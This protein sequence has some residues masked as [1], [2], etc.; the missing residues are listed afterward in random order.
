MRQEASIA[1]AVA[2]QVPIAEGLTEA[3]DAHAH[4]PDYKSIREQ[5]TGQDDEKYQ[6]AKAIRE[7][8]L[9][10]FVPQELQP[11]FQAAIEA[12]DGETIDEIL[13]IAD[14]EQSRAAAQLYKGD[15]PI[16]SNPILV[17]GAIAATGLG[18]FGIVSTLR[19]MTKAKLS[20]KAGLSGVDYQDQYSTVGTKLAQGNLQADQSIRAAGKDVYKNKDYDNFLAK[21]DSV[22]APSMNTKTQHALKIGELPNSKI[23]IKPTGAILD[24]FATELNPTEQKMV[25]DALLA[26]NALDDLKNSGVQSAFNDKTPE[27]LQQIASLVENDPKLNKYADLV[28][29]QYRNQLDFMLERGLIDEKTHANLVTSRPNYVH[30]SR[31]TTVDDNLNMLWTRGA[32]GRPQS[33]TELGM[34]QRST[35]EW[36]GVQVGAAADPVRELSGEWSRIIRTAEINDVKRQFLEDAA[37][38]AE[39]KKYVKQ[40]PIGEKPKD[41]EG[42]HE[43]KVN[44]QSVYYKVTDKALY[45][46]LNFMPY[47]SKG[48][49]INTLSLPKKMAEFFTTGPGAPAFALT[50]SLYDTL[51]GIAIRPKGYDLGL[52][53]EFINKTIPNLPMELKEGISRFDPTVWASGPIGAVRLAYDSTIESLANDLTIRLTKDNDWL[54]NALGVSNTAALR[55]RLAAAYDA[56]VKSLM[57]KT[58]ATTTNFFSSSDPAS[59]ARGMVD[60]APKF[61]SATQ[62]RAYEEALQGGAGFVTGLLR[63]SQNGFERARASSIARAYVGTVRLLHEGFRYQAFATNMPKVI[64]DAEATT[65]LASQ[66]RRLAGDIGQTGAGELY[67]SATSSLM[68]MNVGVQTLAEAGR[69]VKKDPTQV[70]LNLSVALGSMIALQYGWAASDPANVQALK[71]ATDDE[72]TRMVRTFGGLTLNVPPE[73]R[74]VWG[75]LT[76]V[77]NEITGINSGQFN[78]DFADAIEQW[79]DNDAALDE[80]G[81]M[82]L[83]DSTK[84]AMLAANPLAGSNP[85]INAGMVATLGI[86]PSMTRFTGT[87]QQVREQ[88]ISPLGGDGKLTDDALSATAQTVLNNLVGST[89]SSFIRSALDADRALSGGASGAEAVGVALSRLKDN[90]VKSSGPLKNTLFGDYE[91]VQSVS[92]TNF[93]LWYK[94]SDGIDKATAVLRQ[95]VLNAYTTGAD[96]RYA[97]I[98]NTDTLDPEKIPTG[99]ALVPIG[100]I[101]ADLAKTL[102]PLKRQMNTLKRQV[103][104]SQNQKL[105][106]IEQRNTDVNAYNEQRRQVAE[107]MLY[108]TRMYEDAIRNQIGD[109]SFSFQNFDPEKYKNMPWPPVPTVEAT[110]PQ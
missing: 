70:A 61:Y 11:D 95:D 31:T 105:T 2:T 51:T 43:V 10:Q 110:A 97:Q 65:M 47:V 79:L 34:P 104:E 33:P 22:T 39:L 60:V 23:T 7:S 36:G 46:A 25:G 58:G 87:A 96:P 24:A 32:N 73:L 86:D 77:L 85:L 27:E 5:V 56:S 82:S 59:T 109:E 52:I 21:L 48:A 38:N 8:D 53:N 98:R 84:A 17:G 16:W 103:E 54:V 42:I 50:S 63:G 35:E 107:Q 67:Q 68:Y 80:E 94:K 55:D 75:P 49:F 40:I 57:D 83:S 44:G 45:D 89:V 12:N 71:D 41:M 102:Y 69:A 30:M 19:N 1:R 14:Q 81:Q 28:K 6:Q 76:A 64:G 90:T 100:A 106:S 93:N 101:A 92:D 29:E 99:T 9:S 78:P 3:V 37:G 18:A 74:L 15:D 108:I 88:K 20:A 91:S 66:T 13:S 72:N 62:Q 4:I 26:R